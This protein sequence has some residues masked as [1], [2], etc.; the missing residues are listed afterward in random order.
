MGAAYAGL[1]TTLAVMILTRITVSKL[2][3]TKSNPRILIHVAA[4]A[5]T[6]LLLWI[7]GSTIYPINHIVDLAAYALISFGVFFGLLTVLKEFSRKDLDY[8]L[9]IANIKKMWSYIVLELR[10]H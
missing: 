8:L 3:D 10:G 4:A 5:L 1:I 6:G 9:E 2:T 7:I